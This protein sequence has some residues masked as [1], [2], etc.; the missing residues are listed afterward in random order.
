[1]DAGEALL[2]ERILSTMNKTTAFASNLFHQ[3][4]LDYFALDIK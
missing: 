1:M 3:T 2:P 4:G